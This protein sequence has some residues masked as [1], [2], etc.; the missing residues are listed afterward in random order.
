[1]LWSRVGRVSTSAWVTLAIRS[2]EFRSRRQVVGIVPGRSEGQINDLH[3][4]VAVDDAIAPDVV[5]IGEGSFR[6]SLLSGFPR[7][8]QFLNAIARS[9]QHVPIF[10]EVRLVAERA[11]ARNNLVSLSASDRILSAAAITPVILPP[12][13]GSM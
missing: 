11:V 2:R 4:L 6:D 3:E 9:N 13:L 8:L 5:E 10:C 12:V 7:G 1:M